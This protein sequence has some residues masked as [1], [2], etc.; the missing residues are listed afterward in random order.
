MW[1]TEAMR[2]RGSAVRG[3]GPIPMSA[4]RRG[5]A[6]VETCVLIILFVMLVVAV[7]QFGILG[8]ETVRCLGGA[9]LQAGLRSAGRSSVTITELRT[10]YGSESLDE[11]RGGPGHKGD[12]TSYGFL[13]GLADIA[14]D[15]AATMKSTLGSVLG[16]HVGSVYS[17]PSGLAGVFDLPAVEV[18]ASATMVGGCWGI[19]DEK[20]IEDKAAGIRDETQGLPPW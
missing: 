8:V 20:E 7:M 18:S 4:G 11:D 10:L 2:Y 17:R 13:S 5:I 1:N 12:H 19:P 3:R 14:G 9:R 15:L 6:Y 16:D